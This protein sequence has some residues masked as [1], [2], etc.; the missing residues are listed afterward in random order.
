MCRRRYWIPGMSVYWSYF[1]S[2]VG[3]IH[4]LCYEITRV[5]QCQG[6]GQGLLYSTQ[7]SGTKAA[8]ALQP[9]QWRR[10]LSTYCRHAA[11]L[12]R[13]GRW[14]RLLCLLLAVCCSAVTRPRHPLPWIW[15][16]SGNITFSFLDGARH[17]G[18][19]GGVELAVCSGSWQ[20]Q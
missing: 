11:S 16:H 5:K 2:P 4:Q 17:V 18:L 3:S 19:A 14:G 10:G 13:D 7:I 15:L 20:Q 8:S 9:L 12:I 1:K 6:N